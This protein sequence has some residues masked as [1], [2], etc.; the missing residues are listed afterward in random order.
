[1]FDSRVLPDTPPA[2][3]VGLVTDIHYAD[4][5][6]RGTR[7]YRESLAKVREAVAVLNRRGVDVAIE[8]GDFIDSAKG[9]D[10]AAEVGFLKKI[11]GEFGRLRADRH[12]TLGNHCVT[13]LSKEQFLDT[14]GRRRSYYSFDKGGFHF[15][16]LD[17]CFREDGVAYGKGNFVWTDTEV[18]AEQREWLKADLE[19]T[20]RR[21]LVFI[22]QRLDLP[23]GSPYAVRS[24]PAVRRVLE[25]SGKVLAVFMGHSHKNGYTRI[26]GIHYAVLAAVVEGSGPANN[27]YSVLNLFPDGTLKLDGFRRHVEHPLARQRV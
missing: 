22:H 6:V 23:V 16:V 24:S 13:T 21:S 4:A 3:K 5:D 19:A 1:M 15:V 20:G 17:A 8:M 14:V 18:P 11:D 7:H 10:A 25:D 9:A 27:G 26:G 12:Y 2:V